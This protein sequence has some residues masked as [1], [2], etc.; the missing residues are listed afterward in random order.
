MYF[1]PGSPR[2]H[3]FAYPNIPSC[4]PQKWTLNAG[5]ARSSSSFSL[6]LGCVSAENS[7]VSGIFFREWELVRKGRGCW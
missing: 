5:A 7:S 1:V 6:S 3:A 2:L 4:A